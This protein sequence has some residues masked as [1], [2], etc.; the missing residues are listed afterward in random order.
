MWKPLC[1]YLLLLEKI[2]VCFMYLLKI[3]YTINDFLFFFPFSRE[4]NLH[5]MW[6]TLVKLSRL[7]DWGSQ[8]IDVWST[9]HGIQFAQLQF[10]RVYFILSKSSTWGTSTKSRLDTWALT[11]PYIHFLFNLHV[12]L[13]AKWLCVYVNTFNF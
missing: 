13:I 1:V 7:T 2:S 6:E 10:F 5:F 12:L 11:L 8:G 4:K 9:Y 3:S